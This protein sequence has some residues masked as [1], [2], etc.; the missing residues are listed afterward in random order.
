MNAEQLMARLYS[1]RKE[2]SDDPEDETYLAL[3]HAFVFISYN[4]AAFKEYIKNEME[5]SKKED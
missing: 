1:L 4:T 3:H 2:F 5:K